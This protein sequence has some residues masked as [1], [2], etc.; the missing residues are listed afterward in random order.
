M[1]L[2]FILFVNFL[3]KSLFKLIV[4]KNDVIHIINICMSYMFKSLATNVRNSV[5][6]KYFI[7]RLNKITGK[8]HAGKKKLIYLQGVQ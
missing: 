2:L 5:N 8:I 3:V 1:R 7:E 6:K 4:A